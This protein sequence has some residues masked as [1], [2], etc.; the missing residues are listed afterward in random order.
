MIIILWLQVQENWNKLTE[1]IDV[2]RCGAVKSRSTKSVFSFS[3]VC[4]LLQIVL[5][6]PVWSDSYYVSLY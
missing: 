1:E 5:W 3:R 6:L 2:M 4:F